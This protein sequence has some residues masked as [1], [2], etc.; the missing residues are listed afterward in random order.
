MLHQLTARA[1]IRDWEDGMLHRD[2]LEHE[3]GGGGGEEGRRRKGG[4]GLSEGRGG[5]GREV[6]RQG[7]RREGG[8]GREG[9]SSDTRL[10]RWYA[11]A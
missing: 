1:V 7:G 11:S 2:R 9:G 5:E 3:V 4:R 10:G 6:G 8:E